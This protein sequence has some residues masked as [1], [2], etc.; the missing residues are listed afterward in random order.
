[1]KILALYI[2]GQETLLFL[3]YWES[4]NVGKVAV[5]DSFL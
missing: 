4:I 3:G 1:M 2:N 5:E